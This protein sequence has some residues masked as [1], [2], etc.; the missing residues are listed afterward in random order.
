[1][2][3]NKVRF[4]TKFFAI[5]LIF[6]CLIIAGSWGLYKAIQ[7]DRLFDN[8]LSYYNK[9]S[10]D[11]HDMY[12]SLSRMYN[13]AYL[14]SEDNDLKNKGRYLSLS[15]SIEY[16]FQSM[17][18]NNPPREFKNI[19]QQEYTL[20]LEMKSV[21]DKLF[22]VKDNRQVSNYLLQ[23][24]LI[25]TQMLELLSSLSDDMYVDI[26]KTSRT[27]TSTYEK[28]LFQYVFV[29]ILIL[30]FG[31]SFSI[32]FYWKNFAQPYRKFLD[33]IN[34]V[35]K[36]NY[37]NYLNVTE[38]YEFAELAEAF[39]EMMKKLAQTSDDLKEHLNNVEGIV[40]KKT[41]ELQ[42]AY[43]ELEN[44]NKKLVE[45]DELKDLFLQN[46]SHELRT[47]LTSIIGYLDVVLTYTEIP[48]T[49]RSFLQIAHENSL[50][51]LK[52][53]NTLL[54]LSEL[55]A[56]K[57]NLELQKVSI[58]VLL[59]DCLKRI[60]IQAD[61][62]GIELEYNKKKGFS[63]YKIQVDPDKIE[64]VFNNLLSNAIKFTQNGKVTVELSQ[65]KDEIKVVFK[66]TGIGVSPED[67]PLIFDK[68]RQVDQSIA[69]AYDGTGLGLPIV[70]NILDLHEATIDFQS[71]MGEGS[72]VTI[73][74]KK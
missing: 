1:M 11:I 40:V 65:T 59:E 3:I 18:Q 17:L 44:K 7:K 54:L 67:L 48:V 71:K 20:F 13:I 64:S 8:S 38:N 24:R 12:S 52:I 14:Y 46:I 57:M 74:F 26:A 50:S 55:E 23:I 5:I 4:R 25:E 45:L 29:L 66:D 58:D 51:L 16:Q 73:I 56:G 15:A 27:R 43:Q 39:N 37:F 35:K 2:V 19:I 21:F 30:S 32:F 28:L 68:F 72:E 60:G 6:F 69:K 42:K 61:R 34:S 9:R 36:G 62:K 70:K 22:E 63:N 41:E 31:G 53:I 49:Q 47:P 33:S 10:K